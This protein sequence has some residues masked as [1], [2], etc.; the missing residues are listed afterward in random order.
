[1]FTVTP[2]QRKELVNKSHGLQK[3]QLFSEIVEN[4]ESIKFP[5]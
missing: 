1:M 2:G 3:N 4:P 5:Y